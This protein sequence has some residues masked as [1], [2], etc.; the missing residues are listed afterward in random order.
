M[1]KYEYANNDGGCW[2]SKTH[3]IDT[4]D[5]KVCEDCPHREE[6]EDE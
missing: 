4:D 1:R 2:C 3:V 6:C 5:G